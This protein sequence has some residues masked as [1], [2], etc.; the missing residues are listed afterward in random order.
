MPRRERPGGRVRAG[1][2]CEKLSCFPTRFPTHPWHG[3]VTGFSAA[4]PCTSPGWHWFQPFW[5][6]SNDC[7]GLSPQNYGYTHTFTYLSG[8]DSE[9]YR[10][11]Q[12]RSLSYS[13]F[14]ERSN[15]PP[16]CRQ[17]RA[18]CRFSLVQ[19][20]HIWLSPRPEHSSAP[21]TSENS[22][23]WP[24]TREGPPPSSSST[25]RALQERGSRSRV[26]PHA[27]EPRLP[28]SCPR[29]PGGGHVPYTSLV[30][31]TRNQPQ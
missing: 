13:F 18:D 28:G 17:P 2:V 24:C 11:V 12:K 4:T 9:K 14:G 30:S 16:S 31:L 26:G 1:L 21:S 25:P 27:G 6:R 19:R 8:N 10:N 15:A 20:L 7:L 29:V 23:P 5:Q 3:Q 22:P